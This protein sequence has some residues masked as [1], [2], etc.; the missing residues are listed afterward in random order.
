[1]NRLTHEEKATDEIEN[2]TNKQTKVVSQRREMKSA[3]ERNIYKR[4]FTM[5]K[6]Y[7]RTI[8]VQRKEERNMRKGR[9][10]VYK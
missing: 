3:D 1:M 5:Q 8:Y 4:S 9:K 6:S 2:K 10:K 7:I